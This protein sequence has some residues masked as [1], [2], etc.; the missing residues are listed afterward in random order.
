MSL[1]GWTAVQYLFSPL[2]DFSIPDLTFLF[3]PLAV[4]MLIPVVI[5]EALLLHWLLPSCHAWR[6]SLLMNL[7]STLLGWLP[8]LWPS[9]KAGLLPNRTAWLL[10][11]WAI[12]TIVEGILVKLLE[13]KIAA[14][15]IALA[16]LCAN[17]A[18]YLLIYFF[19]LWFS[20]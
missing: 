11:G 14:Q 16:S 18:S 20:G 8:F 7:A 9:M 2:L 13:R 5:I 12:S 3:Y 4:L 1:E 17:T 19:T 15:K 6:D 10:A